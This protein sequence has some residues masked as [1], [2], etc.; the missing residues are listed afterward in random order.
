MMSHFHSIRT[1]L[2]VLLTLMAT[3]V[4]GAVAIIEVNENSS[5]LK[6]EL[7]GQIN[8][9]L[10]VQVDALSV[11]LWNF[12]QEEVERQIGVLATHSDIVVA[13]VIGSDGAEMAHAIGFDDSDKASDRGL[14]QAWD[15]ADGWHL[16]LPAIHT[17]ER[18]VRYGSDMIGKLVIAVS[19]ERV[20]NVRSEF[21]WS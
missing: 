4:Y 5:R 3:I 21:I 15:R 16:D 9:L 18:N 2:T 8:A 17:I 19:G 7:L 6:D 10:D 12:D 20:A 14:I 11:P 13:T 1:R